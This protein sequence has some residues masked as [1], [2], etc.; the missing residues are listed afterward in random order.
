MK[1]LNRITAAMVMSGLLTAGAIA[2]SAAVASTGGAQVAA[3][4]FS[5][6]VTGGWGSA[7]VGGPWTVLDTAASWSVTPGTGS[8][9]VAASG[10]QRAVLGSV[11]VQDVDLLAEMVLPR[12]TGTGHN[13]DG[14]LIGRY[15]GGNS[16]TYYR[17]GLVQGPGQSTVFLRSQRSDGSSLASDLNTGIAAANG[18]VLWLR[19]EF[20]GVNPTAVRA[21]AWAA[22]SS[23]PSTWLLNTTDGTSADQVSG[24]V[25][26]RARNEDSAA[27]HTFAFK[28]YQATALAP[29]PAPAISGFTPTSGAAG[30]AVTISGSGFTGASAVA[31]NGTSASYTVN[32]DTQITAT[33][34]GSAT[35]GPISVTTPGGTATSTSSFTGRWRHGT[36][37]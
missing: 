16:P 24:A 28:S 19:V 10:Q 22:G 9:S 13:C 8:I 35:S 25:G 36:A 18:L 23:E 34:P 11:A 33:V 1:R 17:V 37:R 26:V 31:F 3:D 6:T 21:R 20:Q 32:S 29:P 14:Y 5:R 4:S 12:C 30:T 27:A 15:T 2:A 7:D